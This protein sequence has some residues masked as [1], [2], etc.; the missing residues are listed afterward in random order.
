M[1][2]IWFFFHILDYCIQLTVILSTAIVQFNT[3]STRESK[4]SAGKIFRIVKFFWYNI[5]E[6][7]SYLFQAYVTGFSISN[8]FIP[9]IVL[10]CTNASI[11]ITIWKNMGQFTQ[12]NLNLQNQVR[13]NALIFYHI[14]YT[15]MQVLYHQSE[16][17]ILLFHDYFQNHPELQQLQ[18]NSEKM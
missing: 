7:F 8:F 4:R 6:I 17:P 5:R 16:I 10:I 18:P 11:C 14:I 3:K 13:K 12:I 1:Y 15:Y 2:C 9:L